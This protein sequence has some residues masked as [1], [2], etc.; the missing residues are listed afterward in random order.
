VLAVVTAPMEP[1]AAAGVCGKAAVA[2]I[3]AVSVSDPKS[4]QSLTDGLTAVLSREVAGTARQRAVAV[5]G[6]VAGLTA[7]QP[8]TAAQALVGMTLVPP[9]LPEENLVELLRHPFCVGA[10][11]RVILE[12]L[13]R[14]AGRPFADQWEFARFAEGE[15]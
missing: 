12:Q 11:R 4:S 13:A 15:K 8:W 14:R 6:T 10:T 1:E 7:L 3:V 2:L 5:A 9:P